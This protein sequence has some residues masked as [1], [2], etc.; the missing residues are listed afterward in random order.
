M[1]SNIAAWKYTHFFLLLT[2]DIAYDCRQRVAQMLYFGS[3]YVKMT[4]GTEHGQNWLIDS[5]LCWYSSSLYKEPE[6]PFENV[7]ALLTGWR[8]HVL[9]FKAF[10]LTLWHGDFHYT[11]IFR[12]GNIYFFYHWQLYKIFVTNLIF[13]SHYEI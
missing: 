10:W 13:F 8:P 6:I 7:A 3:G 1:F 12:D 9:V 2:L 11:Y 5:G 4:A